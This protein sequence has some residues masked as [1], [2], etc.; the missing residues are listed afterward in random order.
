M[1]V[2]DL[3]ELE[4]VKG[5]I[6]RGLLRATTWLGPTATVGIPVNV[7]TVDAR[8]VAGGGSAEARSRSPVSR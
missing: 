5:L 7:A 1:S 2:T 8:I 3:Q 6:M 4:E